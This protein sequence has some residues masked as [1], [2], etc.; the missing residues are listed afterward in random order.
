MVCGDGDSGGAHVKTEAEMG[1]MRPQAKGLLEP[2]EAGRGVEGSFSRAFR[3]SVALLPPGFQAS[4][5]QNC[6]RRNV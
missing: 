4:G 2:P 6:E 1:G 5:L 3:G